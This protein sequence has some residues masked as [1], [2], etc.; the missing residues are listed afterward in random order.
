MTD[1][2]IKDQVKEATDIVAVIGQ[3]V[4][5]KKRG[6]NYLGLCPFHTEKTPSFNVHPDRQFFHC[7]GC[8]KGGD[9]FTFLMEHEGWTFPETLKYCADRAGIR[10]P[11]RRSD[12]SAEA[13]RRNDVYEVLRIANDGYQR[14]LFLPQGK[15]ALEYITNR[16]FREET[17]KRAGI[18]YAPNAYDT[19]TRA[20]RAQGLS[21]Q[22]LL[23][24]GL[25]SESQR[26]DR[27]YDRF[28]NR[29]TFPIH[30]LSGKVVGFGARAILPEDEPKYLNSPE[31]EVYHKGQILYGLHFARE[32]IRRA[33]RALLVEG[34]LD[35][36]TMVEN[37]FENVVAV[38]GTALTDQQAATLARFCR[39][40]TLIF[41]ADSA[42]QRA[43]LRGIEIAI[44]AGVSVDIAA[45][46]TGE[47]PDSFLHRH[48]PER[49]R[50]LLDAVSS[51]IDFRVE[52]ERA[53]AG[54]LDFMALERLAKEFADLASRI[55]EPARRDAFLSEAA[56]SL[57]LPESRL[58]DLVRTSNAAPPAN[59]PQTARPLSESL[60]RE[61]E[62]LRVLLENDQY[63]DSARHRIAPSDFE[64][65]RLG[66]MFSTLLAKTAQGQRPRTPAE[67]GE[68]SQE[69]DWWARLLA[70]SIDH[71][72]APRLFED[73]LRRFRERQL[74]RRLLEMKQEIAQAEKRGDH[75]SINRLLEERR[76]LVEDSTES[77]PT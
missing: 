1:S 65:A 4:A 46:P 39:R 9:V 63:L 67:L 66:K 61:E 27:P 6:V 21:E 69:T 59:R 33:D 14:A 74:K 42:G 53:Q 75:D 49:F 24:A 22:A 68:S 58:R 71:I 73:G 64:D 50:Q 16:G 70:H 32:A 8:G 34:Y 45:L 57:R 76:R 19:L 29:I 30:N 36:L 52:R 43:A 15:H 2:A 51:V 23:N 47:D 41:D 37:G 28:R 7:F 54:S 60:L 11:E 3:Y 62:F 48:G 5:L 56:G 26:G 38:S 18:G 35:W 44:N 55:S 40:V 12:D 13:R 10:L 20:A 31:T 72:L 17:L 77:N 25:L